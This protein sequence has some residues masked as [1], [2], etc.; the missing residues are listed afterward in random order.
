MRIGGSTL[1]LLPMRRRCHLDARHG[2]G[3]LALV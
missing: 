1:Y 2:H 3:D